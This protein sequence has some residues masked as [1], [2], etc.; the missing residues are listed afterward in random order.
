MMAIF[1]P[2]IRFNNK[3]SYKNYPYTKS[4]NIKFLNSILL[5]KKEE[6][7]ITMNKTKRDNSLKILI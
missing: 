7:K 4:I 2:I 3:K 1:G 5:I 6:G